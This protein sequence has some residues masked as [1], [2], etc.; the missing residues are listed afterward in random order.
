[1]NLPTWQQILLCAAGVSCLTVAA[2]VL[3]LWARRRATSRALERNLARAWDI[4]E[5]VGVPQRLTLTVDALEET[6]A[7]AA[8]AAYERRR[9][10]TGDVGSLPARA[11]SGPGGGPGASPVA[12]EEAR[13]R[14]VAS[15]NEKPPAEGQ[16]GARSPGVI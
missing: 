14:S 1:M 5:Q 7:I 10:A 2:S 13:S 12:S 15:A 11:A 16:P 9:D 6:D 8:A 4:M 3:W